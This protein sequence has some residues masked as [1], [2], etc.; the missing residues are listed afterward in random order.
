M[1]PPRRRVVDVSA[2]SLQC[3]QRR[4]EIEERG[5]D[6]EA[7]AAETKTMPLS[8]SFGIARSARDFASFI[9]N[10]RRRPY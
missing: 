7:A 2:F 3:H 10:E 1:P 4:G 6:E 8:S 9:V 5:E